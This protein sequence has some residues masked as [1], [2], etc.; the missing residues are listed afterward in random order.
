MGEEG[1]VSLR[2]SSVRGTWR[3]SLLAT[4]EDM[5]RMALEAAICFHRGLAFGVH[6]GTLLS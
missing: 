6:G 3:I 5:Y 4:R 1:C 2:G